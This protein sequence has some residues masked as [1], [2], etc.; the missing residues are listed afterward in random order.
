MFVIRTA[1][2]VTELRNKRI[3][4]S[5]VSRSLS[6]PDVNQVKSNNIPSVQCG[7]SQAAAR[8]WSSV[9]NSRGAA[10]ACLRWLEVSGPPARQWRRRH[11]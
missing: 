1:L 4:A 6:A 7:I 11:P 2:S 3:P 9:P 8:P 5:S 10:L